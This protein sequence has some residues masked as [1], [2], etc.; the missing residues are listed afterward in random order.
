MQKQFEVW[1]LVRGIKEETGADT[2]KV[3]VYTY[4][5]GRRVSASQDHEWS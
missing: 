5:Q 4:T 1:Q 3:D 2:K